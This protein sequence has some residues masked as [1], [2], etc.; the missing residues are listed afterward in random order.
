MAGKITKSEAGVAQYDLEIEIGADTG[1]VWEALTVEINAW[2]LPDFHMVD[3]KSVLTFDARA[4]GHLIEEIPGGGSLLWYTVHWINSGEKTI[5]M[6]GQIAPDWGGPAT[7]F[8]RLVL[9]ERDDG[10]VL[11]VSDAHHGNIDDNNL[12][13]LQ[14]GWSALFSDGL[15]RF[16]EDGVRSD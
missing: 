3:P 2:W 8:L 16:V 9:N 11:L 4:G 1:R 7:S 12:K 13:N 5:H 15:K 10:C 14:E 6:V